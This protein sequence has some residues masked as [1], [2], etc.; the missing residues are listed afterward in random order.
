MF[1]ILKR[2]FRSDS[3]QKE[4]VT[5]WTRHKKS[6]KK[7]KI[8]RRKRERSSYQLCLDSIWKEIAIKETN[9]LITAIEAL[10]S[11]I[12]RISSNNKLGEKTREDL[13]HILHKHYISL[14]WILEAAKELTGK[15]KKGDELFSTLR[16]ADC[17]G[18]KKSSQKEP[19]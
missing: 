12:S 3:S 2:L 10:E 18:K 5:P 19:H 13:R 17:Y 7:H 9:R 11:E 4:K 14:I 15:Y 16:V 8:A 6:V 1:E